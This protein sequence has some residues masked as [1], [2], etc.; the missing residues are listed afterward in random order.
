MKLAQKSPF[1][2]QY[3]ATMSHLTSWFALAFL[4][5]GC[6]DPALQALDQPETNPDQVID[7]SMQINPLF[8]CDE[9]SR[10]VGFDKEGQPTC[11][12]ACD[13]ADCSQAPK[14]L[15]FGFTPAQD[16]ECPKGSYFTGLDK[17]GR[18]LCESPSKDEIS[19]LASQW[20]S[21]DVVAAH[22]RFK[23]KRCPRGEFVI[24]FVRTQLICDS[25]LVY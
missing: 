12:S 21:L 2:S 7:D 9:G 22:E 3:K 20:I 25:M 24:G 10:I 15:A 13:N 18:A 16:F 19:R 8:L 6:N 5:S 1:L 4:I 14:T 17:Q 11:E 23:D